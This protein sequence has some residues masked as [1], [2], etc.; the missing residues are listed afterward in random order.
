MPFAPHEIENKKFVIGM[1][2][3]QTAEVEAF[4][5]AV[6]ADYRDALE[7]VQEP[8]EVIAHIE[9]VQQFRAAAEEEVAQLRRAAEEDA[10]AIRSAAE[11][12]AEECYAEIARQ[13]EQ[14][15]S[16]EAALRYQLAAVELALGEAKRVLDHAPPVT[17]APG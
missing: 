6:A 16:L 8:S 2:G 7:R 9:Q 11:R 12:E 13:A 1:R 5:R 17:A 15:S 3:Y 14:L 10:A 4:L